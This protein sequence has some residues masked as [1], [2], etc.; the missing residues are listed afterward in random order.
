MLPYATGTYT[1][2]QA[3]AAVYATTGSRHVTYRYERIGPTGASLGTLD[4]VT[5]GSI[6]EDALADVH[7]SCT[8][9]LWRPDV[10]WATDSIRVWWRVTM[11]D[12]GIAE[13]PLG[14]FA[15][16]APEYSGTGEVSVAGFDHGIRLR[17]DCVTTRHTL[18]AGA[19]YTVAVAALLTGY[20]TRITAST[21]TLPVAREWPPGTQKHTIIN[22]LLSAI[23]YEGLWFDG[24]GVAVSRP[25]RPPNERPVDATY[26]DSTAPIVVRDSWRVARDTDAVP[27]RWIGVVSTPDRAPLVSTVTNT[28]PASPTSTVARGGRIVAVT[29]ECDAVDQATLDA[30]VLRWSREASAYEHVT[31]DTLTVPV[32]EHR[33]MV[34]LVIPDLGIHDRYTQTGWTVPLETGATMTHS[35]RREL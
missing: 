19:V 12:G 3:R 4:C 14:T 24:R 27:N 35:L 2:E 21:A 9:T 25:Y 15:L 34:G 11:P 8:L 1:D 7:R 31:V 23:N 17:D 22:D 18:A 33:D 5:G 10:V 28:D 20:T 30:I 16:S 26:G 29:Q 6:S 32:H 13:W